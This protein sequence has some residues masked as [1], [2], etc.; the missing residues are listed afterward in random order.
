[1]KKLFAFLLTVFI[2]LLL[3][4]TVLQASKCSLIEKE[5]ADYA[6]EQNMLISEN[7]R[8]ISAIAILTKPDRI[9]KIAI[10]NLGMRKAKPSEIMRVSFTEDGDTNG[11]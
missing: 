3:L 10:K 2:P 7:K 6:K 11:D 4:I 8:K 9:E 5:L 1:M